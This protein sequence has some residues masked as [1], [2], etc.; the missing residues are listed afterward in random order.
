MPAFGA[1]EYEVLEHTFDVTDF[2]SNMLV[3]PF[4]RQEFSRRN[5]KRKLRESLITSLR[6]QFMTPLSEK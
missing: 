4:S 2:L 1:W 6:Q 3:A 5:A